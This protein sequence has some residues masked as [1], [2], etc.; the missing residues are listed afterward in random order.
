M[1][2]SLTLNGFLL[3]PA[4]PLDNNSNNN[5]NNNKLAKELEEMVVV[6]NGLATGSKR[7]G[8]SMEI[9]TVDSRRRRP[10]PDAAAAASASAGR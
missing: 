7:V 8:S 5:N 9:E 1:R 10:W 6:G 3:E 2:F 4:G